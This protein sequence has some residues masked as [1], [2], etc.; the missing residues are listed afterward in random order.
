M[1]S[2]PAPLKLPLDTLT[3]YHLV[4]VT[5]PL[6][7]SSALHL[8][9][10]VKSSGETS[11]DIQFP[12]RSLPPVDQLADDGRWRLNFDRGLSFVTVWAR[13]LQWPAPHLA[14]LAVLDAEINDYAR[15]DHRVNTEIYLR[16]WQAGDG[17]QQLPPRRTRVNLS[18][19]GI[20]FSTEATFPGNGLVELEL[21]LPGV[22]LER[23]RCIGRVI[24]G[25][26]GQGNNSLT[27]LEL[28]HPE[29]ADIEKIVNF[30]M[31]EQFRT[32]QQKAR[33]LASSLEP[34]DP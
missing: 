23:V 24:R 6:R 25:R 21:F 10:V 18:G 1:T 19:Y 9:G 12:P 8:D 33:V 31:A 20:S 32:M 15:R 2:S 5:I 17:R 13:L 3:D 11:L 34:A 29:Q 28:V 22:T 26:D 14:R 30:C 16:F 7:E 4:R 27:A